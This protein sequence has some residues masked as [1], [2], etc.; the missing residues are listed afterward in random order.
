MPIITHQLYPPI[1]VYIPPYIPWWMG[2]WATAPP[3][4]GV[5]LPMWPTLSCLHSQALPSRTLHT[6]A[7][8]DMR[9]SI[10][11][12][13]LLTSLRTVPSARPVALAISWTVYV[14]LLYVLPPRYSLPYKGLLGSL[15]L[16]SYLLLCCALVSTSSLLPYTLPLTVP[17]YARTDHLCPARNE[18]DRPEYFNHLPHSRPVP[19]L[20]SLQCSSRS[21]PVC[22]WR[23]ACR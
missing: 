7:V 10:M 15:M 12:L 16:I 5:T 18:Q 20:S 19:G 22:A 11:S 1:G 6:Y 3:T 21:R 2:T 13:P 9:S 14:Y 23:P 4:V 8:T 17:R